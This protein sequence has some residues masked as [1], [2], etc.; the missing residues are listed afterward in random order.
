MKEKEWGLSELFVYSNGWAFC[1]VCVPGDMPRSEIERITNIQTG[2][3]CWEISSSKENFKDNLQNPLKCKH[4][5][6]EN[7]LHYLLNC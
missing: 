4:Y 5:P 2:V 7:R 1:S 6:E 3:H